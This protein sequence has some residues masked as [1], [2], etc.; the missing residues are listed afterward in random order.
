DE[1][2]DLVDATLPHL[3]RR[4]GGRRA[5]DD[6]LH[7]DL[8]ATHQTVPPNFSTFTRN[9]LNS[10]VCVFP[11]PTKGVRVLVRCAFFATPLKPQWMGMPIWWTVRPSICRGTRRLVTTATAVMKPRLELTRTR[12]PTPIPNSWASTSPISMNFSGWAMALSR[13]CV[14]QKW[15]CSVSR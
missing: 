14:V 12:S 5:G 10:G 11:S 6:V 2:G 7:V 8:V 1:L 15:K 3:G 13:A 9:D 4:R